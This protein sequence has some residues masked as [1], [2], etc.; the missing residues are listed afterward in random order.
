MTTALAAAILATRLLS[1][2]GAISLM[3]L[4]TSLTTLPMGAMASAC[5]T[6]IIFVRTAVEVKFLASVAKSLIVALTLVVDHSAHLSMT[7]LDWYSG[8]SKYKY[9][10]VIDTD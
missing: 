7:I 4:D 3:T 8:M 6:R 9:Q 2:Q 5:P 10:V 1:T